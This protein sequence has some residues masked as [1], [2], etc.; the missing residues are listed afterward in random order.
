VYKVCRCVNDSSKFVEAL[1]EIYTK[2]K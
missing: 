1:Q 2:M